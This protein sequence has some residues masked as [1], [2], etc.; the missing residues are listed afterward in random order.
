MRS[1]P[2]RMCRSTAVRKGARSSAGQSNCL[3]SSRSQVRVL[4]GA[5]I[6]LNK[7]RRAG[8][9]LPHT[10]IL[11]ITPTG[12]TGA[13]PDRKAG[14]GREGS[15]VRWPRR[16]SPAVAGE[17]PRIATSVKE[18][19]ASLSPRSRTAAEFHA[20]YRARRRGLANNAVAGVRATAP[21]S[22]RSCR[23]GRA[24]GARRSARSCRGA[25]AGHRGSRSRRG[26]R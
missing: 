9:L 19:V 22:A 8:R 13:A 3:L 24:G 23:R 4:P 15:E 12:R 18:A 6:K 21:R 10:T 11:L 5:P 16:I 26:R 14:T 25:R 1:A 7:Q 17:P 20:D 2:D